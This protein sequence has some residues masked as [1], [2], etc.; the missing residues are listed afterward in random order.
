M[1]NKIYIILLLL[2]TLSGCDDSRA[3]VDADDFGFPKVTIKASGFNVT[4][5]EE[6]QL[7]EW[8]ATGHK[9]NGDPLVAV[10]YNSGNGIKSEWTGWFGEGEDYIAGAMVSAQLCNIKEPQTGDQ[11]VKFLN[12]EGA[13]CIFTKGQGLYMLFTDP[14]SS[15]YSPNS[16]ALINRMPSSA[17][18]NF[19]TMGLWQDIPIYSQGSLAGGYYGD[20][21]NSAD[22]V[23]GRAYFKILDRYYD[24]NSGL[25]YVALKRGFDQAIQPPIAWTI[26]IVT[27]QLNQTAEVLF[28]TILSNSEYLSSLRAVILLYIIISGIMFLGGML[29]MSEKELINMLIRLTIVMQLLTTETSWQFFD[30]YFFQ[31]FTSGL[32]EILN[33]IVSTFNHGE[34][35]GLLFFDQFIEL[36][37]SY[38]TW[39]KVI[40]LIVSVPSGIVVAM[41]IAVAFCTFAFAIVQAVTLYLLALIATSILIM[42]GPIFIPFLL[43]NKTRALFEGWLTRFA[44]YFFQPIIVFASISMFGQMVVTKIYQILGFRS[45]YEDYL[46]FDMFGTRFVLLKEW[47]ICS[48]SLASTKDVIAVPGYGFWDPADPDR[49]CAP[50]ECMA[51]RYID[52]PFLDL[53]QDASLISAYQDPWGALNVPMLFNGTILVLIC[54]VMVKLNALAADVAQNIAG[55]ATSLNTGQNNSLYGAANAMTNTMATTLKN[56]TI[57]KVEFRGAAE[58]K[59]IGT[60]LSAG[61]DYLVKGAQGLQKGAEKKAGEKWGNFRKK[62]PKLGWMMS[63]VGSAISTFASVTKVK[64]IPPLSMSLSSKEQDQTQ[65]WNEKKKPDFATRMEQKMQDAIGGKFDKKD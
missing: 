47:Q 18:A 17:P 1:I 43:F 3:P 26:D 7:S 16:N 12:S 9:Y 59:A 36:L 33:L 20:F 35:G 51:E 28:N 54:Y 21:P 57:D 63:G 27:T 44:Q 42:L 39:L 15:V 41:M 46:F 34:K 62:N 37:F 25:Y 52:L 4:G 60:A 19:A 45:C 31:L 64:M 56:Y 24:D 5:S 53:N 10:V 61:K 2:L 48:F 32:T 13:P 55:S 8:V 14:K 30:Q 50:Y 65:D 29:E 23:G 11:D 6:N 49:F 58:R 38:E 22:Y 40:S